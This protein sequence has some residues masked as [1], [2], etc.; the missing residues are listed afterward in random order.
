MIWVMPPGLYPLI[1]IIIKTALTL[2][3]FLN[4]WRIN[5]PSPPLHHVGHGFMLLFCFDR[6]KCASW[7]GVMASGITRE[8]WAVNGSLNTAPGLLTAQRAAHWAATAAAHGS[9]AEVETATPMQACPAQRCAPLSY[10]ASWTPPIEEALT[11]TEMGTQDTSLGCV[12]SWPHKQCCLLWRLLF[13]DCCIRFAN[14][15]YW[16]WGTADH[17]CFFFP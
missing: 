5:P 4:H 12:G 17:L 3:P 11:W 14:P 7:W 13:L 15:M 16:I 8:W 10:P 1:T 2:Q 9:D 6:S